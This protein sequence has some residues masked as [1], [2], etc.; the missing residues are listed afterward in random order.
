MGA[1]ICGQLQML[2]I[3]GLICGAYLQGPHLQNFTL[4]LFNS[5]S[6]KLANIQKDFSR[7]KSI[8]KYFAVSWILSEDSHTSKWLLISF[9]FAVHGI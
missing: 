6:E 3:D 4:G 7:L 1:V 8:L 9:F 5:P 2:T